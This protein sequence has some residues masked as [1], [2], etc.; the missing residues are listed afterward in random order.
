[1]AKMS[2]LQL[3]LFETEKSTHVYAD[4]SAQLKYCHGDLPLITCVILFSLRDSSLLAAFRL[5][6]N[7][8]SVISAMSF[9]QLKISLSFR[10]AIL[11]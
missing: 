9:R 6:R 1:M 10:L 7:K 3:F 5:L 11:T 2:I 8:N 4:I